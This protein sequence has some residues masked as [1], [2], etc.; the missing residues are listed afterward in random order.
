ME[1]EHL[2]AKEAIDKLVQSIQQATTK[3]V[4]IIQLDGLALML[5]GLRRRTRDLDAEIPTLTGRQLSQILRHL[6][7]PADLSSNVSHWGMIDR[8]PGYRERAK[9]LFR[10]GHVTVGVLAPLDLVMSKLRVM[11]EQDIKDAVYLVKRFKI[12]ETQIRRALNRMIQ[13]SVP[14]T[15]L[16]FFKKTVKGFIHERFK[17]KPFNP[18]GFP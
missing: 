17:K 18:R 14:S 12:T 5:Y 11:H 10:R 3:P 1:R 2:V 8:P 6:D 7:I 4:K 16:F 9:F 15:D 13:A